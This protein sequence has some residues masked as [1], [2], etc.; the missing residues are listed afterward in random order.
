TTTSNELD[1]SNDMIEQ[2]TQ[3][4][5]SNSVKIGN[6]AQAIADA[7]AFGMVQ[8]DVNYE[9][10]QLSIGS[11]SYDGYSGFAIVGGAK[12]S[13]DVFINFGATASGNFAGSANFK[14]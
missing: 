5:A 10:L 13:N 14:F 1:T 7:M 6:N 8:Q 2:N 12:V 4:I 11:A 9:G 3:G